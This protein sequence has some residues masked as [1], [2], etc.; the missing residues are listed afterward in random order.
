MRRHGQDVISWPSRG[1]HFGE[2]W[3]PGTSSPPCSAAG[4]TPLLLSCPYTMC[5]PSSPGPHTAPSPSPL[6]QA[7]PVSRLVS[8][9]SSSP[10]F[11]RRLTHTY[12]SRVLFSFLL[13]VL[14]VPTLCCA[15]PI[16]VSFQLVRS[17]SL[18]VNLPHSSH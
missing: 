8:C 1:L 12:P 16:S 17:V 9:L 13:S 6:E 4:H 15:L 14:P 18:G 7:I 2:Q 11:P 10:D 3:G 5:L